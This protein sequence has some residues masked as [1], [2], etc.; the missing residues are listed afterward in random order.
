[1]NTRTVQSRVMFLNPFRLKN[2]AESQPAGI[3]RLV[4]NQEQLCGLSFTTYRT[5]M[6]FLEVPAI[7]AASQEFRQV[8]VDLEELDV[9]VRADRLM[10]RIPALCGPV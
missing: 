7:G 9:C 5:I 1:M 3:Y 6:A 8:P 10:D 4:T 2:I